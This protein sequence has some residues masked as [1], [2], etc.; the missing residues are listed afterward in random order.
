MTAARRRVKVA[1]VPAASPVDPPQHMFHL[2]SREPRDTRTP[3]SHPYGC[4]GA[5]AVGPDGGVHWGEDGSLRS[6]LPLRRH[7]PSPFRDTRLWGTASF[8]GSKIAGRRRL[9]P[10]TP[11]AQTEICSKAFDDGH[12]F[13]DGPRK[14]LKPTKILFS[15]SDANRGLLGD[16]QM[17]SQR[18]KPAL[19]QARALSSNG[20]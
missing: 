16:A 8:S 15:V 1:A 10:D 12:S 11:I 5:G 9:R 4:S 7:R 18:Q 13:Q 17:L 14:K 3:Q 2:C 6:Y 19:C 20:A